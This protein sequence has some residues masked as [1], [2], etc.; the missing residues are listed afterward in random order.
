MIVAIDPMMSCFGNCNL[1]DELS[2][3]PPATPSSVDDFDW[4]PPVSAITVLTDFQIFGYTFEFFRKG[5]TGS[6]WW[7]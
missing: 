1:G 4:Q 7:G 6:S 2:L 5:C 3:S